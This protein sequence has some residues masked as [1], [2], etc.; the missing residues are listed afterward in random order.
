VN[1]KV[2]MSSPVQ[3]QVCPFCGLCINVPHETQRGCIDALHAEIARMRDLL[4][5]VKPMSAELLANQ[6]RP[7]HED[8]HPGSEHDPH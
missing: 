1:Q 6:P 2:K 3:G 7:R 5:T 4:D 8:G